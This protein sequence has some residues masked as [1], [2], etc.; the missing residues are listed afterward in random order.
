MLF[1]GSSNEED[2]FKFEV[3]YEK[4]IIGCNTFHDNRNVRQ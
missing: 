2:K 1:R 3:G 4:K